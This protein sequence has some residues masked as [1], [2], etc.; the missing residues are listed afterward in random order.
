MREE[1]TGGG[2]RQLI[3]VESGYGY[4]VI[5][6]DLHVFPDRGPLYLLTGHDRADR[7]ERVEQQRLMPSRLLNGRYRVV[8]FTGRQRERSF[9]VSW[10][11]EGPRLRAP[12]NRDTLEACRDK[13]QA[14]N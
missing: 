12:G 13:A 6:A 14:R 10:R 4:G 2:P 9:L 1:A 3:Q 5:G 11:G 7:A 8:P